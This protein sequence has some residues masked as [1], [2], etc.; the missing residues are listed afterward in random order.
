MQSDKYELIIAQQNDV[1]L[2][3]IKISWEWKFDDLWNALNMKKNERLWYKADKT[4]KILSDEKK[5]ESF[6]CKMRKKSIVNI[7]HKK[8]KIREEYNSSTVVTIIKWFKQ[9]EYFASYC[10][11]TSVACA[12]MRKHDTDSDV[13]TLIEHFKHLAQ[14]CT[15]AY[16]ADAVMKEHSAK[17]DANAQ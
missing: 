17:S 12:Y 6:M 15:S 14:E 9:S 2:T 8:K 13:S 4:D 10:E 1:E 11:S 3:M 5:Y 16:V 7:I